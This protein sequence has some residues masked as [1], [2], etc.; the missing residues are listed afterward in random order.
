MSHM[1]A[2]PISYAHLPEIP[3]S[4]RAA[5]LVVEAVIGLLGPVNRVVDLGG[6]TGAW[7][8]AFKHAGVKQVVC[9]DHPSARAGG[10]LVDSSEFYGADL[11]Q[12]NPDPIASDLAISVEFAEHLLP[13]RAEW[14][15]DFLTRSAPLVLFSAAIP[16]QGGVGHVNEQLPDYWADLFGQRGYAQLDVIRPLIIHDPEIPFWYRQNLFLY[17][18]TAGRMAGRP[19]LLPPDFAAIHRSV[20][21]SYR[22]PTLRTILRRLGPAAWEAIV[23]RLR[24]SV[25]GG[26]RR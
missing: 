22:R 10:L 4:V 8:R 15:V 9:L 26:A 14:A 13:A 1:P 17:S 20:L 23:F 25:W 24:R 6:G 16:G 18:P 7:C 11:T 2:G 5:G 3:G 12:E 19:S 21:Q